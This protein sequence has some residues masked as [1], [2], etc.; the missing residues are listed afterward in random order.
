MK[1]KHPL[2]DH[3]SQK[4]LKDVQLALDTELMF[5]KDENV[6]KSEKIHLDSNQV[7]SSNFL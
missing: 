3:S 1:R 4:M 7:Q 6:L 5:L 2:K